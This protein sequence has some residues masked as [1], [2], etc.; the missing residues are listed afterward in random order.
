MYISANLQKSTLFYEYSINK[1]T[2]IHEII[3]QNQ[4]AGR[5]VELSLRRQLALFNYD[6]MPKIFLALFYTITEKPKRKGI[7]F[8]N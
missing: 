1:Y 4:R 2:L 8:H 7:S 3:W 6:R 5:L